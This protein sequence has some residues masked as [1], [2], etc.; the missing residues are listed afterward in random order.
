MIPNA[1]TKMKVGYKSY[2]QDLG[3]ELRKTQPEAI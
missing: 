3:F 2:G 1:K